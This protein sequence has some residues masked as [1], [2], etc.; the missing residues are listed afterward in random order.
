VQWRGLF[1]NQ[2]YACQSALSI[3]SHCSTHCLHACASALACSKCLALANQGLLLFDTY[4]LNHCVVLHHMHTN[5]ANC[6][7]YT[8]TGSECLS[9]ID[10]GA[11]IDSAVAKSAADRTGRVDLAQRAAGGK[12]VHTK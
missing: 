4:D 5:T 10:S 7:L 12:I 2:S 1:D 8:T 6:T 3:A 9:S 11:L